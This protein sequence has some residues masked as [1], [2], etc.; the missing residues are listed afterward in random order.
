M[1]ESEETIPIRLGPAFSADVLTHEPDFAVVQFG[2]NDAAV[3]VWKSPP[4]TTPRVNT[5]TY[6]TNLQFFVRTLVAQHCRVL[7]MTPNPMR[8]TKQLREMYGQ[9]PYQTDVDDGFNVVLRK[10]ARIVRQVAQQESVPL[11]DVYERFTDF[12]NQVDT[13]VDDLLLDGMHPNDRGH[14]L[15]ADELIPVLVRAS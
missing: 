4:V 2:I 8:W 5:E 13:S 6:R 15:I 12:G 7:L 14:R 10:Y 3:N 11:I 9:P 1:L